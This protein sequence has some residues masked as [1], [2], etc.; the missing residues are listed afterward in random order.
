MIRSD[1]FPALHT[2]PVSVKAPPF[3]ATVFVAV[4]PVGTPIIDAVTVSP[5]IKPGVAVSVDATS[6]RINTAAV[7][8][9]LEVTSAAPTTVTDV[10]VAFGPAD[11]ASDAATIAQ[12]NTIAGFATPVVYSVSDTANHIANISGNALNEAVDVTITDGVTVA[13]AT[14]IE[15]A[16]NSGT[17]SVIVTLLALSNSPFVFEILAAISLILYV[18]PLK[19]L[20]LAV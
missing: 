1:V 15:G 10:V 8:V 2:V 4:T 6:I 7:S 13:Q 16:T 12:A 19:L 17:T 18:T 5:P 9:V 20:L 3:A 14:T 11:T